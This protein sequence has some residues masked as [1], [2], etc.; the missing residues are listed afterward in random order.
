MTTASR[1]RL[2]RVFEAAAQAFAI[3]GA[4][5][6]GLRASLRAR[7]AP[8]TTSSDSSGGVATAIAPLP[9]LAFIEA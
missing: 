7:G 1:W 8:A 6:R 5:R 4:Q 2:F 3:L 9:V